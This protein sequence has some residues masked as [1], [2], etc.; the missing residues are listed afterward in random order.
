MGWG[1]G[2]G[3]LYLMLHCHHQNNFCSKNGCNESQFND[4]LHARVKVHK[5][6]VLKRKESRGGELNSERVYCVVSSQFQLPVQ[7]SVTLPEL[8]P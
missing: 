7:E 6:Q 4:S 1:G 2:G 8:W 3:E 5:P